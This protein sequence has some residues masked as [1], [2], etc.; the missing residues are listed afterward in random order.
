MTN[1]ART[2]QGGSVVSF[3]VVG[4]ILLF[5]VIGGIYA[6]HKRADTQTATPSSSVAVSPSVQPSNSS[7]VSPSSSPKAPSPSPTTPSSSTAPQS[8]RAGTALPATG[9]ADY[10]PA[11]GMFA[12]LVAATTSYLRSRKIAHAYD[13]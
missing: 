6:V 4:I 2:N 7:T 11:G 10:L 13:R 3:I 12:V 1:N 9:P 5:I 8:P